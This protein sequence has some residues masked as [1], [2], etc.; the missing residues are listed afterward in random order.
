MG[1]A[2]WG[3]LGIRCR[4]LYAV[5]SIVHERHFSE[6]L[7]SGSKRCPRPSSNRHM[8]KASTLLASFLYARLLDKQGHG[9]EKKFCMEQH[10]NHL[11]LFS[12]QRI[13]KRRGY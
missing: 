6:L 1:F 12:S 4:F 13:V 9:L 11:D 2:D 5:S 8:L 3:I 7:D 10:G